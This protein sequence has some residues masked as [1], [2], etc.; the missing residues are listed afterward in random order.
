MNYAEYSRK[1]VEDV[2]RLRRR[3][4]SGVIPPR[5]TDWNIL[6]AT[7]NLRA[8]AD[9]FESWDENAGSPKRNLR[10]MAAIAEI[11]QRFNV[12][13]IQEVKRNTRAIRMLLDDFLGAHWGVLIEQCDGRH[14]GQ[15]G[16]AGVHL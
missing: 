11:V 1:A 13:A 8:F 16:A 9:V 14:R 2:V 3:L 7:W 10:A 5:R 15:C 12:V 6:V 4:D